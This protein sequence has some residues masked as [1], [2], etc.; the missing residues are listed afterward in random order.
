[1]S[2]EKIISIAYLAFVALLAASI[3]V[4][5]YMIS[6]FQFCLAGIFIL[7][8]IKYSS[9]ASFNKTYSTLGIILRFIP[10]HVWIIFDGIAR[11]FKRLINNRPFLVFLLFSL[12]YILGLLH[13]TNINTALKV[14][15]NN[16]PIFLLP[17]FFSAIKSIRKD[18][19]NIILLFFVLS[20]TIS[21]FISFSI[22]W[23]GNYDD[24]RRISPFI[25]H[26]HLSIFIS[27]S[28]FIVFHFLNSGVF[29]KLLKVPAAI[30]LIWLVVF[31]F[32][33]LKSL[34]GVIILF[35]GIYFIF[36]FQ[37]LFGLQINKIL[38]FAVV[39]VIPITAIL[40]L[41]FYVLRFYTVDELDPESLELYTAKGNRYHHD[42]EPRM[43]ENGHYV[44][45]YISE[46]EMREEW[47][48]VSDYD[49]DSL[50]QKGQLLNY[51]LM[52]YLASK[53]LRKDAEGIQHL[54]SD[55][56]RMVEQGFANHIFS[57]KLSLYPRIYQVLWEFD[58][59]FKTGNPTGHSATQRL[60]SLRMGLRI[61]LKHPVFGVG[62]GDLFSSYH[63]EYDES[64]SQVPR[65]KRITGANQFLNF[66]VYFGFAGLILI[67]FSWL[68]P[69]IR[70]KSFRNPIFVM[71]LFIAC[72]AMFSEEILRFQTGVSFF[73]Y[74][75]SF[76]VLLDDAPGNKSLKTDDTV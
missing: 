2:R 74:F 70:N 21:S 69:A 68:Y 8:G 41:F 51:T 61:I 44:F 67:L 9:V 62:T 32:M 29:N 43:L 1:M 20:V 33:I 60:E 55:D 39:F 35:A 18:Q 7:D 24:I 49:Y 66:I 17:L 65:D 25:N 27:F 22:F 37:K 75:Y 11:Q 19:K 40:V 54:S 3:P 15:R 13:T 47:N 42:L 59:Y 38:R 6:V 4:S 57:R 45:I 64:G 76:F 23:S 58:M 16:L 52:R 26:I 46:V 50:D 28:I 73:A 31:Q 71:F 53:G 36:V 72:V 5:R 48:K 34:T 56:I 10:F 30:V 14:L 63:H 12:V